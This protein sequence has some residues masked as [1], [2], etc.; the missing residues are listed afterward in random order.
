MKVLDGSC[1]SGAP[2]AANRAMSAIKKLFSWALDRGVITVHPIIGMRAPSKENTRDR[3]L[4]DEEIAAF[5]HAAEDMGF[6]FGPAF[7]LML[8]T[9]QRRGEVTSMRWSQIEGAVWTIPASV[10]KNG[11]A[12]QVPLSALALYQRSFA[13]TH[14]RPIA[15][16]D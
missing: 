1:A 6:P 9:G 13:A 15:H 7:Q 4:T 12:H 11:R 16:A 14:V 2:I 3:V 10:A 8:L 5:W